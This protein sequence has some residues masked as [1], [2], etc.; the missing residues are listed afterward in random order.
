MNMDFMDQLKKTASDVVQ[1]VAHKS[2]ELLEISKIKYEVH[3]LSADIKKLYAEIGR[4]VYEEMKDGNSLPE[5]IQF[6][7]EIVSA[8]KAKIA[9]LR[10]R[11]QQVK[12]GLTCPACGRECNEDDQQCPFCGSDLAEEVNAEVPYIRVRKDST[13]SVEV[14]DQE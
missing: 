3:D 13:E 11:E 6:K 2:N 1:T 9:A 8:K 12:Q 4:L 14:D 5:D 7:C 10:A